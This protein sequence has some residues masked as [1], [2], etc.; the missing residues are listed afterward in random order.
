MTYAP[1]MSQNSVEWTLWFI[2]LIQFLP[3]S[4]IACRDSL[5]DA[6]AVLRLR[7]VLLSRQV[8]ALAILPAPP[9][10]E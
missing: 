9:P 7:L 8:A 3:F 1:G 5:V 2:I 4:L 10:Y 6:S